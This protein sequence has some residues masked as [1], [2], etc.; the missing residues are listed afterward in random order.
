MWI[1]L[2]D[3]ALKY[4]FFV[5]S[6]RFANLISNLLFRVNTHFPF[7]NIQIS[8]EST[9]RFFQYHLDVNKFISNFAPKLIR[10]VYEKSV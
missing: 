9:K 7:V 2:L 8:N 4:A 1:F 5:A 3:L 10:W 6:F